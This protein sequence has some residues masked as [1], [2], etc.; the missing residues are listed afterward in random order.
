MR[1]AFCPVGTTALQNF[2]ISSEGIAVETAVGTV[3]MSLDKKC[4]LSR[5][6]NRFIVISHKIRI[7]MP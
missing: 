4:I 3:R 6:D 1:N 5:R 7:C 2:T